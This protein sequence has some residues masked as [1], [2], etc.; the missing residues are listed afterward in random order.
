MRGQAGELREHFV[1]EADFGGEGVG[2]DM[3][4][5]EAADVACGIPGL[6]RHRVKKEGVAPRP[7]MMRTAGFSSLETLGLGLSAIAVVVV[8]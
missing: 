2:V 5:E 3:E 1:D 7:P 8:W 6:I 4:G